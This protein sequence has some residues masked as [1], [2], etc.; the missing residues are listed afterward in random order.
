[1]NKKHYRR[2]NVILMPLVAFNLLSIAFFNLVVDPYGVL[3]SLNN[4]NV[5]HSE[6]ESAKPTPVP[7]SLPKSGTNVN[8]PVVKSTP[9]MT[10]TQ[11]SKYRAER[12][13]LNLSRLSITRINPKTIVLGTSTALRLSTTHPAL[14]QQPVYNLGLAGAKMHDIRIYFED[15]LANHPDLKQVVIGLDFYSF[16][17]SEKKIATPKQ[18][19]ATNPIVDESSIQPI[20]E[21]RRNKYSVSLEE[22]LKVNFSLDTFNASVK[23]VVVNS[24][25]NK[26]I[27][28]NSVQPV[29]TKKTQ[30]KSE[31]SKFN[32]LQLNLNFNANVIQPIT[33]D[34]KTIKSVKQPTKD[35]KSV[36]KTTKNNK[37]VQQS[38]KAV[39]PIKK[40][41][42]PVKPVKKF[43]RLKDS[44]RLSQFRRVID[45][46]YREKTFYK[47]YILSS[48]ELNNFKSILETCKKK[49][50]TIK[51]FFS[52]VHAAQLEAIYTAG[53]WSD[54]EEWKR[55]VIAMTP[56]WDFSDYSNIT[57][58]PINNNMENF[59]DSV[60]YDKQIGDL[61][62]NRLYNSHQDSVPSNFGFLITPSNIESHLAKIRAERQGWL[63]NNQATVQFVQD[64]K[65]EATSK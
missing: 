3:S 18:I 64:I 1:M 22:L 24:L 48:E 56:A 40:R 50:I 53:L 65:K 61:I 19:T 17:R 6:L 12:F 14:T 33:K 47:D 31:P 5:Q 34:A 46:Y 15:I 41:A 8:K 28:R 51:V 63:K 20:T 11:R 49:K 45:S 38:T 62:L 13:K 57:T 52:P 30:P 7:T 35:V 16:G 26:F 25:Q 37:P 32:S 55:Q 44:K 54:F 60:H 29:S 2:F 10:L 58:E 21:V 59:V 9:P 27:N 42:N 43:I 36:K 4:S 23:K 39:K